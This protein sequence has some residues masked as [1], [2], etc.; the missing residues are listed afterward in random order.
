M[1]GFQLKAFPCEQSDGMNLRD[2]FAAK[3]M[4]ALIPISMKTIADELVTPKNVV[5]SAYQWADLMMKARE[6]KDD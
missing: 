3:A 5:D 6:K 1:K 4:Q 2:Y